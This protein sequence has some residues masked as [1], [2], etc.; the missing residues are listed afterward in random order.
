MLFER[1]KNMFYYFNNHHV[2]PGVE[3]TMSSFTKQQDSCETKYGAREY[4]IDSVLHI[5]ELKYIPISY[6]YAST[7]PSFEC[8][9]F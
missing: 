4:W 7:I 3:I 8:Q 1:D 9:A 2:C 6:G 5:V